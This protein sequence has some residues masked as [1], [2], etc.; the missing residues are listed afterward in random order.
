[1]NKNELNK[2]VKKFDDEIYQLKA[3]IEEKERER[4]E[5]KL[6]I[7][8]E[9][10]AKI[11]AGKSFVKITNLSANS[12]TL[13]AL[14]RYAKE[15]VACGELFNLVNNN[16]MLELVSDEWDNLRIQ[17]VRKNMLHHEPG[18]TRV[19]SIEFH[20]SVLYDETHSNKF[21]T[22]KNTSAI[23]DY[24]TSLINEKELSYE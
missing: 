22:E 23:L 5:V 17:R 24:L 3:M 4:D 8:D 2:E 12:R 20:D 16:D 19:A 13:E 11:Q 10:F 18:L 7:E 6:L 14:L 9:K 1:M 15:I 21:I